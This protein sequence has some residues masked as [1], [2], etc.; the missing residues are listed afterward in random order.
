M[1]YLISAIVLLLFIAGSAEAQRPPA[2]DDVITVAD[3]AFISQIQN[4]NNATITQTGD[5]AHKGEIYQDGNDN[6]AD[7]EQVGMNHS[8]LISQVGDNNI[9]Y[10]SSDGEKHVAV[11]VQEGN[12]HNVQFSIEG[13]SNTVDIRQF[14]TSDH[15]VGFAGN[16]VS[17]VKQDGNYNSFFSVQTGNAGGHLITTA[18]GGDYIQNGDHNLIDVWQEGD[19]NTA[20]LLQ[21]GDGNSIDLMQSGSSNMAVINQ[22]N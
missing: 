4:D 11:I 7:L 9:G 21:S 22:S 6:V 8:G 5:P 20:R 19:S 16:P 13:I 15:T 2:P 3:G 18:D 12:G 1:R 17:T 10:I 14:G